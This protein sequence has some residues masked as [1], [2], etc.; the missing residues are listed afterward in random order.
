MEDIFKD[1]EPMI[2][3]SGINVPYHWWAG[4]TASRFFC[5]IRDDK[6]ITGTKCGK[7]GRVFIPPKKIC[8]ECFTENTEWV[9]VSDTGTVTA[10]TIARRQLA[11]LKM[12]VPV[13]FALIQLDGADTALLHY[14]N[15]VD[16]DEIEIGM[17]VRA[18]FAK[19]RAGRITDIEYFKPV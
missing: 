6:K 16:P 19:E 17:R 4:E 7:C 11:A 14:L 1:V 3:K 9:D 8:P 18:V 13:S 10:F 12:D 2:Y 15:E 5:S